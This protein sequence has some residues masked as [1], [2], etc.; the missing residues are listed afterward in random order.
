MAKTPV[1]IRVEEK[2]QERWDAKMEELGLSSRTA[3]IET[4]V[5]NYIAKGGY[6][7]DD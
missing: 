4:A 7:A 6:E 1:S 5:E 2:R 3:L